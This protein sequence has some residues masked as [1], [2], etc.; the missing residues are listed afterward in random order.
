[1][2]ERKFFVIDYTKTLDTFSFDINELKKIE[3]T[4]TR[5]SIADATLYTLGMEHWGGKS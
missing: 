1:V 3:L 4:R 2:Y 5:D